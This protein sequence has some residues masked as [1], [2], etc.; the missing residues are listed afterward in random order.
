MKLLHVVGRW[1]LFRR[2]PKPVPAVDPTTAET[3]IIVVPPIPYSQSAAAELVLHVIDIVL[4]QHETLPGDLNLVADEV[5]DGLPEQIRGPNTLGAR[6][7]FAHI[8][9][10]GVLFRHSFRAVSGLTGTHT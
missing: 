8:I 7:E 5:F 4:D 1:L 3:A 9:H 6:A 10:R 2:K